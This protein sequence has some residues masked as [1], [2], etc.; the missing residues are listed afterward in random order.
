ME[1]LAHCPEKVAEYEAGQGARPGR[2]GAAFPPQD[3]AQAPVVLALLLAPAGFRLA[4][5]AKVRSG[6]TLV[7]T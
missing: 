7:G 2:G 6:A 4:L 5:A 1:E 3:P